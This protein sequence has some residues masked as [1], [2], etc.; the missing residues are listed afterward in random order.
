MEKVWKNVFLACIAKI[1]EDDIKKEVFLIQIDLK[2]I[3]QLDY[4]RSS[5]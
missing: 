3:S 2:L 1:P 5:H 4:P